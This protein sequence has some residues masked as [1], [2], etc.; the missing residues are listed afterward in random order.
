MPFEINIPINA[1]QEAALQKLVDASENPA[2]TPQQFMQ[3]RI[4]EAVDAV[5]DD[6]FNLRRRL[7][8]ERL[9]T[10]SNA[11]ISQIESALGL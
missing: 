11:T 3:A 7:I 5:R 2:Q 8:N 6:Y 1:G 4:D 10:A 9:A